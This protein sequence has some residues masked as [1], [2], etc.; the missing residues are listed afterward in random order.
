MPLG[1]SIVSGIVASVEHSQGK[2][3]LEGRLKSKTIKDIIAFPASSEPSPVD[4]HLIQ[5][6]QKVSIYYM[7]PFA[8]C[9]RLLISPYS[10]R[11]VKRVCI[12]ERGK[13]AL[14]AKEGTAEILDILRRLDRRPQGLLRSSVSRGIQDPKAILNRLKKNGWIHERATAP[15]EKAQ[16]R[17]PRS[18]TRPIRVLPF[19]QDDLFGVSTFPGEKESTQ[20]TSKGRSRQDWLGTYNGKKFLETAVMG[21]LAERHEQ[22]FQLVTLMQ[23]RHQ[24]S[25]ILAPEVH[26]A[27]A[28]A[29]ELR[30]IWGEKVEVV[31]GRISPTLRSSRWERIRQGHVTIVVGTRSALFLPVVH[32]GLI[33]VD[34]EEDDSYKEEQLPYYHAREV[35]RMRGELEHAMVVY[36]S[37]RPS[38]EV[39][40]RFRNAPTP[41]TFPAVPSSIQVQVVDLRSL[42]YGTIFSPV[43][44]DKVSQA[45]QTGEQVLLFLNQKGYSSSLIC[46][47]CG[48]AP[49]CPVC[50]VPCKLFQRPSRLV[51]SLCHWTQEAPEV[52]PTCQGRVFRYSGMGTQRLEEEIGRLFPSIPVGRVDKDCIQHPEQ[53]RELFRRFQKRDIQ[54]LI[55]T[56]LVL[57]QSNLPSAKVVGFLQADLGLH[58][59]DY[60]S[61]E[62]TFQVLSKVLALGASG[63]MPGSAIL[64]TRMPDHHVIR[65]M[66]QSA[67]ELFYD[68]E[69]ELR[70]ALGYP[71]ATHV[72]LVI[73]IGTVPDQFQ[74]VV[75][76]VHLRLQQLEGR[77][78]RDQ[79]S[80]SLEQSGKILGPLQSPKAGNRK[81]QRALFLIKTRHLGNTGE[82]IH[83]ITKEVA[84]KG[85]FPS[86]IVEV[87]VNPIKIQ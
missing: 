6:V 73:V 20:T 27:E 43:L 16:V 37:F 63:P 69:L 26:Q 34:Q 50:R 1:S 35:A 53:V 87:N 78:T 28:W 3:T 66:S 36:G 80:L 29:A 40:A 31:H 32:L 46:G 39:Y 77:M 67:P 47:D 57:H 68:Q 4:H 85:P 12:T 82:D 60:R 5:L 59:P 25:L 72:V 42:P 61:A 79:Q 41:L 65:A 52:C 7:A 22:L 81:N 75:K 49:N 71:P 2:G 70:E 74:R 84:E 44:L 13:R 48:Q 21:S 51:C 30:Q 76:L 54:I 86:V 56:E 83:A 11:V 23:G 24:S 14:S 8:A 10:V 55:G 62:R 33:W 15:L 38:L 9:L 18:L 64:Q 17:Q 58:V 45:I 19:G